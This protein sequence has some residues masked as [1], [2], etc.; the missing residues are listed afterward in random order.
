VSAHPSVCLVILDGFGLA[1]PGP[2]NAVDLAR[3]PVFDGLWERYP[4]GQLTA[5][6]EAVGLPAGQMGNSEVGHLNLGAGSIVP[7][8]LARID[9]AVR[10]GSLAANPVLRELTEGVSRL[11]VIGLVSEGGVHSSTATSRRSIESSRARACR[12]SSCTR[13]RTAATP[14][15][16]PEPGRS[17]ASSLGARGRQ[18]AD[19]LGHRPLLRDGPRQALGPHAAGLRPAGPRPGEHTAASGA[20]PCG[21][22]TSA[23]RRTSSSRDGR[24]RRRRDPARVTRLLA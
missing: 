24:R 3:T 7:Q 13:S 19:R 14:R 11:H 15:R 23:K 5:C 16:R 20:K 10:D 1:E 2:G 17:S 12:T 4:H 21:R 9:A 18:R 8:D 6:G 22:R